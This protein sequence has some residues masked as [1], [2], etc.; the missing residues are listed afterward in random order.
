MIG[1]LDLGLR[2]S[3]LGLGVTFL[4]LLLVILLMELLMRVFPAGRAA[5]TEKPGQRDSDE[6]QLEETAVALA[7]GIALLEERSAAEAR[8][9]TLGKLL[10]E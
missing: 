9:P 7:V 4:A 2:L 1:V 10:E 5:D 3:L 8:D 6:K